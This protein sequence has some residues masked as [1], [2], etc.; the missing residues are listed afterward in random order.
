MYSLLNRLNKIIIIQKLRSSLKLT[1]L[2]SLGNSANFLS[3]ENPILTQR[4]PIIPK[5]NG[6][7]KL[8]KLGKKPVIFFS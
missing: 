6:V 3:P 1:V 2:I 8:I 7:Q 4:R 5:I